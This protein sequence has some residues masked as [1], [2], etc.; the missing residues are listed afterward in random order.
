M[1]EIA[2]GT[3]DIKL[4]VSVLSDAQEYET[5]LIRHTGRK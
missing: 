2:I 3:L 5:P 4:S 1:T